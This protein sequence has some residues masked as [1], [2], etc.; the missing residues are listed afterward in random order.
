MPLISSEDPL[1]KQKQPRFDF[2]NP[3]VDPVEFAYTLVH[4]MLYHGGIGLAAPQIGFPYRV[5]AIAANPVLVCYNPTII[6]TSEKTEELEEGCLTFPKLV[7]KIKRPA[8]I[9]VRYTLPNGDTQTNKYIGMT[10]RIFQHEYD[11][12]EG[13]LFTEHVGPVKLALAKARAKK[14]E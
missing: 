1:L 8:F 9:R 5:F 10:A 12:L 2:L 11:H 7:L 3:P 13:V 4:N 14:H 6:D